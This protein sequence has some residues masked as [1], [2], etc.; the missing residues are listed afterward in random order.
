MLTPAPGILIIEPLDTTT[1]AIINR[2]PKFQKIK[3]GKVI[4]IGTTLITDFGT[5]VETA[6]YCKIGDIV[7]FISYEDGYDEIKE[8]NKTY[9]I[10]KVQDLRVIVE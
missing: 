10:V 7:W 4:G 9:H 6:S 3:K 1:D 2:A 5:P 8:N